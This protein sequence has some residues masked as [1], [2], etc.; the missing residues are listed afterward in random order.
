[1]R[2]LIKSKKALGGKDSP[3]TLKVLLI[4]LVVTIVL[5][6]FFAMVIPFLKEVSDKEMCKVSVMAKYGGK[7]AT[8]HISESNIA[9]QCYSQTIKV[10][11]EG[12]FKSGKKRKPRQ[13]A[14]FPSYSFSG[15]K[16]KIDINNERIELVKEAVAN[17]MFD[18]W[19]Q[20]WSGTLAFFT[21]PSCLVCSDISFETD[22]LDVSGLEKYEGEMQKREI[23]FN[24]GEYL[25]THKINKEQTYSEYFGGDF[26]AWLFINARTNTKIVFKAVAQSWLSKWIDLTVFGCLLDAGGKVGAVI[27]GATVTTLAAMSG[28]GGITSAFQETESP[29]SRLAIT[30]GS[31]LPFPGS[32]CAFG[33][34][35]GAITAK[36][37]GGDWVPSMMI[38]PSGMVSDQCSSMY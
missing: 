19:D 32:G 14:E 31:F 23:I 34:V 27:P 6:A 4:F 22:W 20:F 8:A 37:E 5:I 1:M 16:S 30:A 12:I 29:I 25:N 11:N 35:V 18:C 28:T 36:V 2:R 15:G 21:E 10:T 9:L 26:E 13:I 7:A 33:L 17:E 38:G 24:F 3:E